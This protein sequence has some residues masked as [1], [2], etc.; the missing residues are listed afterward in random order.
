M[1]ERVPDRRL[2]EPPLDLFARLTP[3]RVTLERRPPLLANHEL[4]LAELVRLEATAGLQ[5][6][7]EGEKVER[8]DRLEHVDLRDQRFQNRQNAFEGRARQRRVIRAKQLLE[9]VQLVQHFLEPQLVDLM[10]DDEEC[11]VVLQLAR[12]RRLER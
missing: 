6:V 1:K 5:P 2:V 12:P 10:D 11:F 3:L 9:K 8:G 4:A 7:A